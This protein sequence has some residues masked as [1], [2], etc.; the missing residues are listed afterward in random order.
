MKRRRRGSNGGVHLFQPPK[1]KV[2]WIRYT[3]GGVQKRCS[4][5]HLDESRARIY[6]A[7]V[8]RM[9]GLATSDD[10]EEKRKL[11]EIC[12]GLIKSIRE[13]ESSSVTE[14]NLPTVRQWFEQNL[15]ELTG[16]RNGDDRQVKESSI[17]RIKN[18]H[19]GWLKHLSSLPMPMADATIN[20]IGPDEVKGFLAGLKAEGFSGK[21]RLF[22]LARIRG[23]FGRAVDQGLLMSNPA[24]AK[25]LGRLKFDA[26]SIRI[27]FNAQ[28]IAAI[29]AAADTLPK[30]WV[31]LSGMLG[32]YTGQ[33]IGDICKMTWEG[34]K[35]FD[36]PLP[37]ISL[38]QEKTGNQLV[39]PVAEPLRTAL[40]TVP[41]SERHGYLLG[42]VAV[43][44]LDRRHRQMNLAWRT[45]IN[46][47]NLPSLADMPVVEKVE[48]SGKG[49][50]SYCYAFHSWRHTVASWLGI[51]RAVLFHHVWWWVT[52]NAKLKQQHNYKAGK[53]WTYDSVNGWSDRFP[54]MSRTTIYGHLR[55][56]QMEGFIRVGIYNA[57]A[58]DQT[59]WY[60]VGDGVRDYPTGN[61]IR[62]RVT[63]AVEHGIIAAVLIANMG[64]WIRRNR[65]LGEPPAEDGRFWRYVPA[66]ELATVMP[67]LSA[68]QVKRALKKLVAAG[69]LLGKRQ[70]DRR[71][72]RILYAFQDEARFTAAYTKNKRWI[73]NYTD[74][75]DGKIKWDHRANEWVRV[76]LPPGLPA[77]PA[78][79]DDPKANTFVQVESTPHTPLPLP[80]PPRKSRLF[81]L[82]GD[83]TQ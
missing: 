8:A 4:T 30:K 82:P 31:K 49:R 29:F 21:T 74:H 43:A 26:D 27:P 19:D 24:G 55:A 59:R 63:D 37:T 67:F 2:W 54:Y 18:V 36:G 13:L 75:R 80:P 3:Q 23:A 83:E 47:A 7:N 72:F 14:K 16:G 76:D 78:K 34:L 42:E 66:S 11:L 68:S 41:E 70:P 51:A 77:P 25:R 56:L 39:I 81:M 44:Y 22:A 71:D 6:A 64:Y 62:F 40:K 53:F 46:K 60:S 48:R 15:D 45:L 12:D 17:Q 73:D 35:D 9:V 10:I 32:L 79:K 20:R 61:M 50:T 69:V 52:R 28:Q 33:R 58:L 57:L 38:T 5:G 1:S 65:R